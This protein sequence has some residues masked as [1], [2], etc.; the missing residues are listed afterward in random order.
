M[1]EAQIGLTVAAPLIV[2]FALALHRMGAL[3][4]GATLAAVAASVAIAV[5]LFVTQ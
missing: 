3:R 2:I 5:V 4:G 1:S